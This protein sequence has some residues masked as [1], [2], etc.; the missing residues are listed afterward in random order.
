MKPP[1]KPPPKGHWPRGKRRNATTAHASRSIFAWLRRLDDR[2]RR[3][4]T[5]TRPSP[6]RAKISRRAAAHACRCDLRT[7]TRWLRGEDVPAARRLAR[8]RRWA[9]DVLA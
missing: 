4:H 6:G 2:I 1:S 5:G 8:L 3:Q 9:D 7:V